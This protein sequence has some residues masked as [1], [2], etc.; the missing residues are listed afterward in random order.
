MI[1]LSDIS[2]RYP[3][4]E[5]Q[6]GIQDLLV[7]AGEKVAV[8]KKLDGPTALITTTNKNNLEG[9]LDDRLITTHPDTSPK[10]TENILL[11]AADI[12]SGD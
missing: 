8:I 6:L 2:F 3:S 9:Q 4:G 10:Q 7:K 1:R 11:R 5:F 12:A